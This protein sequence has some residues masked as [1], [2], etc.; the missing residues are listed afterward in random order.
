MNPWTITWWTG[1]CATAPASLSTYL[2]RYSESARVETNSSWVVRGVCRVQ[3]MFCQTSSNFDILVTQLCTTRSKEPVYYWLADEI[4]SS[5]WIVSFRQVRFVYIAHVVRFRWIKLPQIPHEIL[6]N[7]IHIIVSF[8]EPLGDVTILCV[9]VFQRCEC[10]CRQMTSTFG[11]IQ[12][13]RVW[14]F[15]DVMCF[16]VW[17]FRVE[18]DSSVTVSCPGLENGR[19]FTFPVGWGGE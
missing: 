6:P 17:K 15:E 12:R 13:Y 18:D 16:V 1:G 10:L 2:D 9:A 7:D 4:T 5:S 3:F 11:N 14:C 8:H 19:H